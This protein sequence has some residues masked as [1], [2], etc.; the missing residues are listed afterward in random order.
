MTFLDDN[1]YVY[2]IGAKYP[3]LAGLK[4][5][6]L[7]II[8]AL[9]RKIKFIHIY[10]VLRDSRVHESEVWLL[11]LNLCVLCSCFSLRIYVLQARYG[12]QYKMGTN[13]MQF[14]YPNLD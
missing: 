4:T 6:L 7:K 13:F 8:G 12:G 5:L 2:L 10:S 14:S 11:W 1:I 9:Y 3:V